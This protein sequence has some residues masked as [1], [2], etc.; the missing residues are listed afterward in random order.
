MNDEEKILTVTDLDD[1]TP[2]GDDGTAAVANNSPEDSAVDLSVLNEDELDLYSDTKDLTDIE[3]ASFP[4]DIRQEVKDLRE[5]LSSG[6]GKETAE[7]VDPDPVVNKDDADTT[8]VTTEEDT[9]GS[10]VPE[11]A[12]K[13]PQNDENS[14]LALLIEENRKLK[15]QYS[16]LQG[17]YNK[18]IKEVN[19]PKA[20]TAPADDAN[21]DTPPDASSAGTAETDLIRSLAE[22][23]GL[24]DEVTGALLGI[25][26]QN[27]ARLEQQ[28]QNMEM[29]ML[30]MSLDSAIRS[31]CGVSLSEIDNQP[32]FEITARG[33]EN[34]LKVNAW[35][36]IQEEKAKGNINAVAGI[37][38][39]VVQRMLSDGKWHNGGGYFAAAKP[40]PAAGIVNAPG[41]SATA[42]AGAVKSTKPAAVVPHNVSGVT[43][44]MLQTG[45]TYEQV[46][47]EYDALESRRIR[48]DQTV[49]PRMRELD[50][51]LDRLESKRPK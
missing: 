39:Q 29:Q 10:A 14:K 37:V 45:R 5:K 18:E 19:A 12:E 8:A 17:K 7:N 38:N 26:R 11:D 15:A 16:T 30:N 27:T 13:E 42:P 24:D 32:F 46:Q 35:D 3:L 36:A 40:A 51:E 21:S 31:Q 1:G 6:A 28:V 44:P 20:S 22:K 49:I 2:S 4:P 34:S 33:M 23:Y 25:S 47:R 9:K 43:N 48:G 50:R 41:T